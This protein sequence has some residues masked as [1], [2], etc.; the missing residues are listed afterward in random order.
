MNVLAIDIGGTH[1]KILASGQDK[2][3]ECES[4]PK[5]TPRN[6]KALFAVR[7]NPHPQQ[8]QKTRLIQK[9]TMKGAAA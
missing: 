5:L 7:K 1:V 3:Q 2:R 9:D 6:R 4:G 8:N